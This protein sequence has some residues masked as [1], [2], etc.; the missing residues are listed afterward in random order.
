[1]PP[2]PH[3]DST[4]P[5]AAPAP[6]RSRRLPNRPDPVGELRFQVELPGVDLGRFRECTGLAAEIEVKD[7]NEGG[8][9]DRVHKLPTRMKYPNLVLKRG[10]TYED[11]LLKW[12]WKTQRETQRIAVTVS[13]MGPDGE[14]V[15]S[16]VFSEAFP[17][18]WT[19]PEPQRGLQPGRHRDARDR[20]R[21]P[22]DA[23]GGLAPMPMPE[24]YVKAKLAIESGE[25]IQ[26]LF[27][28]TEFTITK[29]NNW[30]FDPIKGTSLPKGK[31]GGG[32]PREMQVNL[33]LDQSLPERRH[34]GQGHHRQAS[35]R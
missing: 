5:P 34:V 29:G 31:F 9:N 22:A 25:T 30:T 20:P 18:K 4:A 17:I 1:M 12:L 14:A 13:L 8:V 19:G 23:G 2:N 26:A 15:R 28:P 21:R 7:Y 24:G 33:L 16:W 11:A 27:N 32:K 10:V 3:P 6:A 35:S